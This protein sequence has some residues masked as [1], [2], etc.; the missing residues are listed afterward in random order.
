M[1]IL[2]KS[3]ALPRIER[4]FISR[5][6][7]IRV[8]GIQSGT[9]TGNMTNEE[10]FDRQIQLMEEKFDGQDLVMFP[11]LMTGIYFGYVREKRWFD[12]AE[13]FLNGKTTQTMLALSKKLKTNICYSMFELQYDGLGVACSRR[14]GPVPEDSS[15]GGRF[16]L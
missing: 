6:M 8:L 12:S 10:Y 9:V 5:S 14:G 7:K 3:Y 2:S 4:T 13:D 15:S 1:F 16:A 11:E